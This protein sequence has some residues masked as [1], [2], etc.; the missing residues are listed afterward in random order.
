MPGS[1]VSGGKLLKMSSKL[2]PG[3][4]PGVP[5]P[6]FLAAVA[7]DG[8]SAAELVET[9]NAQLTELVVAP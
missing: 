6:G 7:D 3:R 9:N 8:D 2:V 5:G 4:T 1:G